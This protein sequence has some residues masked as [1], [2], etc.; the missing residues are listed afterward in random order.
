MCNMTCIKFGEM[1]LKE[2]EI[3]GLSVI[4]VG[5]VDIN[6]SLRSFI[7]KKQPAKYVGVDIQKGPGV[8]E[9]CAAKDL[10]GRFGP[11]SFDLLIATELLEH[12]RDW[13]EAISNFKNILRPNGIIIITTRSKG[14][15]YHDYP[16][17]YWRY[18][19]DDMKAIFSDFNIQIIDSDPMSPGVFLKARK[20]SVF[21]EGDISKQLLYSIVTK[22]YAADVKNA[23]ISVFKI[24]I[25]VK[26]FI[27]RVIPEGLQSF[28]EKKI[29]KRSRIQ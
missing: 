22:K 17:D 21:K 19:V 6:G 10:V 29:T 2:E 23:D 15:P 11:E 24:K 26:R 9:I 18:G 20:P 5:A 12:I 4:E 14:Y 27:W 25:A 8:D 7:E 3:R 28:I 13:K 16:F 1:N